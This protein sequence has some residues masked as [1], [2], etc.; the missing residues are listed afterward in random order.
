MIV[1]VLVVDF[2]VRIS[3]VEIDRPSIHDFRYFHVVCGYHTLWA[4]RSVTGLLGINIINRQL[5]VRTSLYFNFYKHFRCSGV[6]VTDEPQRVVFL[7]L[8]KEKMVERHLSSVSVGV[9]LF[10]VKKKKRTSLRCHKG[11]RSLVCRGH[12]CRK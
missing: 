9:S 2:P 4:N 6:R 3:K 7:Y 12:D 8:N 11:I 1:N 10:T 5:K